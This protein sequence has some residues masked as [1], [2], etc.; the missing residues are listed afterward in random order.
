MEAKNILCLVGILL[1]M[2]PLTLAQEQSRDLMPAP[3]LRLAGSPDD[4]VVGYRS[5]QL[6]DSQQPVVYPDVIYKPDECPEASCDSAYTQPRNPDKLYMAIIGDQ[7]SAMIRY[8]AGF[9]PTLA[10]ERKGDQ[11]CVTATMPEGM[12]IRM[13]D[14]SDTGS[15]ATRPASGEKMWECVTATCH[16][17]DGTCC[18]QGCYCIVCYCGRSG[19]GC[20]PGDG[21]VIPANVT[22]MQRLSL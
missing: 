3:S 18:C 2:A 21:F 22:V 20:N 16:W 7:K 10:Y 19:L 5:L 12:A 15:N 9:A 13:L 4:L 6:C 8:D 11:Y 1:V 14:H 17:A